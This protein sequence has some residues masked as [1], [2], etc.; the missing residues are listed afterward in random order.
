MIEHLPDRLDLIATAEAGRV[1]RGSVAL[2]AVERLLPVLTSGQGELQVELS[3]GKDAGGT[4]FLAGT[5]ECEVVLRCQRCMQDMQQP[6]DNE[7]R[8][9]LVGDESAADKLP[10]MY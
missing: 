3:L 10:D 9:G 1:L 7:F 8:L 5:I 6:L 4:R 2:A